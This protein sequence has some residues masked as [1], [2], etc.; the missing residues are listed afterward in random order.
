MQTS[1]KKLIWIMTILKQLQDIV[2]FAYNNKHASWYREICAKHGINTCPKIMSLDGFLALP[3]LNRSM[4]NEYSAYERLSTEPMNA[5]DIRSTSGTS[6]Q[7]PLFYIRTANYP[8]MALR[9]FK[10]GARRKIYLWGYQHI[11]SHVE[12]DRLQGLQTVV[13][14]P[15]QLLQ[16]VPLVSVMNVDTLAGTPSLLLLFGQALEDKL[17]DRLRFR[18]LEL[19]GEPARPNTLKA[20]NKLFPLAKPYNHYAMGEMGQET[21][22]RTPHCDCQNT[23][24]FH[25]SPE[26]I[27]AENL[28][29]TL[30]VTQLNVPTAFPLI[31]YNTGDQ[32]K[33][34]GE[35][36]CICGHEGISFELSGRANVDF[37][38]IAGVE[39]RHEEF[40]TIVS[41]LNGAFENHV[42]V[43]VKEHLFNQ[44][45][46]VAL[47]IEVVP[48]PSA[49]MSSL[50]LKE[51]LEQEIISKLR[52]SATTRLSDM[53]KA[54]L[55]STP[56]VVLLPEVP[57]NTKASG[58]RLIE[59]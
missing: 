6:G 1:C 2:E 19:T 30:I 31:R 21:G 25:L 52:L 24:Y 50:V 26:G 7:D 41:N 59:D 33:W 34:L 35:D 37:V 32:V 44:S 27:Y 14:D 20:L 22:I 8:H 13:C 4:L 12:G 54:G 28:D 40:A 51:L 48:K 29:G 53:I 36:K 23:G 56:K 16:H 45:Q 42:S 18:F 46:R 49:T 15:Q 47:R 58:I 9:L 17:E 11:V 38:R 39:L 10:D 5:T 3:I 57:L 43:E 55:F